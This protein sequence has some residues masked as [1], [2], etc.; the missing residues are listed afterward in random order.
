[1]A[2]YYLV[3]Q[4]QSSQSWLERFAAFTKELQEQN[5]AIGDQGEADLNDVEVFVV[6]DTALK[7][8]LKLFLRK[9]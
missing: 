7:Y 3:L 4:A 1:M 6:F 2:H 9:V 8:G 5:I